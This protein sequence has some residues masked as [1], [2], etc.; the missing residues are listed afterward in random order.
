M[1]L[2]FWL[3][4]GKEVCILFIKLLF[5]VF[6][7]VFFFF[8]FNKMNRVD[9]FLKVDLLIWGV[10]KKLYSVLEKILSLFKGKSILELE[11]ILYFFFGRI[12]KY[13]RMIF[14][15]IGKFEL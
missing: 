14:S 11:F 2:I 15:K 4:R 13:V 7:I 6:L 12:G 3:S 8:F 9:L 1:D 10:L 5:I